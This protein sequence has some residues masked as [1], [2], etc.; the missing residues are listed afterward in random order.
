MSNSLLDNPKRNYY[1]PQHNLL[2]YLVMDSVKE[3]EF[4]L[5]E[6]LV[7]TNVLLYFGTLNMCL[8]TTSIV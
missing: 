3:E 8:I 5:R 7:K 6:V 4:A 2:L 1:F